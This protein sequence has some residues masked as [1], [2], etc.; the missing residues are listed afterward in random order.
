MAKPN[1]YSYLGD[2]DRS[3]NEILKI[4]SQGTQSLIKNTVCS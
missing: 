4:E 1:H 2:G 3:W